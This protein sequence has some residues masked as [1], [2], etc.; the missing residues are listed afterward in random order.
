MNPSRPLTVYLAG[1][2]RDDKPGDIGWREKTI[3][4]L[5]DKAIFLNPLGGKTFDPD[6]KEWLASGL[7]P[8]A[9]FIVDH[10][11]WCVDHIDAAIFNFLS[12]ADGYPTIGSLIEFG[13]ATKGSNLLYSIVPK[14]F[15]GHENVKLFHLHPFI[16]K[17][18]AAIFNDVDSCIEFL[19]GH[20]DVLSG[21]SPR[22]QGIP[23]KSVSYR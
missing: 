22:F 2:I 15:K 10:D 23:R 3:N 11:F 6:T 7:V 12:M 14:N 21:R 19:K 4:A 8:G 20:L 18:S 17:N 1:S 13:R 16:E 5:V 9:D